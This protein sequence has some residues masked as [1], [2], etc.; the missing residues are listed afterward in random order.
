MVTIDA[1]NGALDKAAEF[2]RDRET[3]PGVIGRRLLGISRPEDDDLADHLLRER[4]RRSTMNGSIGHS[5][6]ETQRAAWEMLELGAPADNAGIVR[7]TG[8]LLKQQD[9]PGRWSEDGSAGDGFFSPAPPGETVAPLELR[10][11]T[12]FEDEDEARF[13]ASCLA[14]RTVL[15]AGHDQRASVRRHVERLLALRV[16]E[17]HL[18]F[19]ALGAIGMAG[20]QYV[21]RIGVLMQAVEKT[22]RDDGSWPGVTIFHAVD[23]LL[24]VPTAA[25]RACLVRAADHI[26]QHQV[27]SGAFDPT[28]SE[29]VALI[30]V[31]A[32][33][34]ARAFG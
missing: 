21:Q 17:P 1:L 15:R 7:M 10:S 11:G 5:L 25:A 12:R 26:V 30:A 34:S 29:E 4:R 24:S 16:L 8:Y 18:S 33:D 23:M 31:R 14:L 32:L 28:E 9:A 6:I 3:R 2:F 22:Q 27:A 13:V 19:V 20:P